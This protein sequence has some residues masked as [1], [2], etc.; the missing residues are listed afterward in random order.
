MQHDRINLMKNISP[1]TDCIIFLH[2]KMTESGSTMV[3]HAAIITSILYM[4]MVMFGQS[5][6]LAQDRSIFIGTI[7]L[8]YML[9]F[10]HGLPNH[11]NPN[12]KTF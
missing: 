3:L 10:G 4:A 5:T 11:M 9:V 6:L 8:L 2:M 1:V 12:L 7:V